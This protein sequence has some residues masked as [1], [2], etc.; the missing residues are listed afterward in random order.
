MSGGTNNENHDV[1]YK[2]EELNEK[3][4]KRA[5]LQFVTGD[6]AITPVITLMK[7]IEEYMTDNY[8]SDGKTMF[9]V[10]EEYEERDEVCSLPKLMWEMDAEANLTE[11]SQYYFDENGS[12]IA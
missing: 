1:R 12:Y 6:I 3:A 2:F 9:D 8:R 11:I 10:L 5:V 7:R 4:K